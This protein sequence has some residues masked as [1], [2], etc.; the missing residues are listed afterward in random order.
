MTR[1]DLPYRAC[2]GIAVFNQDGLV[3][4]GRR[5]GLPQD[6]PHAWQMPQGGIDEDEE[7]AV[8]AYRELFEETGMSSVSML[9]EAPDWFNYDLPPGSKKRW[10]DRF[11]GQTQKWFAFRFTGDEGEIRLDMHQKPEFDAW[12]WAPISET[13]SLIVPFKRRVYEQVADAFAE[14][15]AD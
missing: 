4:I 5:A 11:R 15:A 2:V 3:F 13:P 7:P 14:Y 1:T 6:A 12:R 8:A 10:M 9:G